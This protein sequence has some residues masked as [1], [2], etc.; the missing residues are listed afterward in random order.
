M[1][2]MSLLV[3]VTIFASSAFSA[4]QKDLSLNAKCEKKVIEAVYNKL[5]KD[6]ETFSVVSLKLL[7]GGSK[8][9]LNFSPVVLVKTSDEVEPRDVLVVTNWVGS[10]Y[11]RKQ[12]CKVVSIQTLADGM[13]VDFPDMKELAE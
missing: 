6:D 3:L 13:T 7:Y 4:E 12:G 11:V 2:K 1:I 5:G 10:E 8:G 9:G